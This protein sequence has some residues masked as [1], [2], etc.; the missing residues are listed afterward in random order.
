M[1]YS[2][3]DLKFGK[4]IKMLIV[5]DTSP[6]PLKINISKLTKSL[7][8]KLGA[9]SVCIEKLLRVA[10]FEFVVSTEKHFKISVCLHFR[11]S[12]KHNPTICQN[13]MWLSVDINIVNEII[14]NQFQR[15]TKLEVVILLLPI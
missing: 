12:K 2:Y 11:V 6:N 9:S 13:V 1:S 5:V 7:V 14:C 4:E 8:D 3:N 10:Q 15:A